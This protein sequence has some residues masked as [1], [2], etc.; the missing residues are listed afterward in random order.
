ME[1]VQESK[2]SWIY[3]IVETTIVS[4]AIFSILYL[5]LFRPNQVQGASMQPNLHTGERVITE[6]VSYRFG[7]PERGDIVVV[8][9]PR[10]EDINLI[11]RII[12]LPGERIRISQ[13][14]VYIN[15]EA[16][17]EGYIKDGFTNPGALLKEG[18][19]YSIPEGSYFVMGDNRDFSSDSRDF[20]AVTRDLIQ[21]KAV[22]RFW[23]ISS[24]GVL[25]HPDY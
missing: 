18:E 2:K 23:P 10:R 12:G 6:L 16:L 4:L 14:K 22:L 24:S 21:G 7:E 5:F 3:E 13:G 19:V 9:S 15:G 1:E 8:T 17:S 20:G 25:N 11:K